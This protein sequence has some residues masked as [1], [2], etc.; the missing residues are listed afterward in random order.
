MVHMF[1]KTMISILLFIYCALAQAQKFEPLTNTVTVVVPNAPGGPA[2]SAGRIFSDYLNKQGM[3]SIV[4]NKPGAGGAVGAS[5]VAA[6][7]NNPYVLMVGFK[8]PLIYIPLTSKES[9]NY[10]EN[11]FQPVGMI[12]T[13]DLALVTS[14]SL[15]STVTTQSFWSQYRQNQAR[16]N[17]GTF[18][19]L[20]ESYISQLFASS[21]SQ[22]SIVVYRSSSQLLTDL[23]AD[24]VQVGLLDLNSA[25]PLIADNKLG[26]IKD[27]E[28]PANV[29][30]WWAIYAA[31]GVQLD[32]VTYYSKAIMAMHRDAEFQPRLAKVFNKPLAMDHVEMS[33]FHQNEI[34]TTK[35]Y[36]K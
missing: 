36:A 16:I 25:K 4:Q 23:L 20:F 28:F 33:R 15:G 6:Q 12:G 17:F 22:P 13:L 2:D 27:F 3:V 5:Y 34:D 10:N 21:Q 8:S 14:K 19:G 7:K 11:T 26:W 18:G 30:T 24:S 1:M 9:L 31:P 29:Q 32:A 35:R